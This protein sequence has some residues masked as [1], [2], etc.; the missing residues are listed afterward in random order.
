MIMLN[1]SIKLDEIHIHKGY[2][3][4]GQ[5]QSPESGGHTGTNCN[6]KEILDEQRPDLPEE[7]IH[8]NNCRDLDSIGLDVREARVDVGENTRVIGKSKWLG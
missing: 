5:Y 2:I 8:H 7:T 3:S 4:H 1:H 6:Q